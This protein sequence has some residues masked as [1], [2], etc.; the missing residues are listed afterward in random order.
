MATIDR[1]RVENQDWEEEIQRPS[2]MRKRRWRRGGSMR[3][4]SLFGVGRGIGLV[5]TRGELV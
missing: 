5:D 1:T 3:L 2:V 4:R